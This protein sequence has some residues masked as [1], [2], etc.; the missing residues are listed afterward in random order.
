MRRFLC[1][2]FLLVFAYGLHA[3]KDPEHLC[4]KGRPSLENPEAFAKELTEKTHN[5]ISGRTGKEFFEKWFQADYLYPHYYYNVYYNT[6]TIDYRVFVPLKIAGRRYDLEFAYEPA[7]LKEK[8]DI[9]RFFP[10][11]KKKP[12][13][14]EC[15]KEE[16]ALPFARSAVAGYLEVTG[17]GTFGYDTLYGT[18]AWF[19]NPHKLVEYP[20]GKSA[21][22]MIDANSGKV[23]KCKK[24]DNVWMGRC[25]APVTMIRTENGPVPAELIQPGDKVWSRNEAGEDVLLPVLQ[26]SKEPVLPGQSIDSLVFDNGQVLLVSPGHPGSDGNAVGLSNPGDFFDQRKLIEKR[27]VINRYSC[28]RDLLTGGQSGGY[29]CGEIYLGST[30]HKEFRKAFISRE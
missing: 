26:I 16:E 7:G 18:F 15:M 23:L 8:F 30:L 9:K 10:N 22:I 3:Q 19:F 1:S 20:N 6:T 25:L 28:T 21:E 29:Y 4:G 24:N 13:E 2:G 11:C 27:Q 12:A 14:C 17:N 5:L